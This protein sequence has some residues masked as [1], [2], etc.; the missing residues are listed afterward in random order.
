MQGRQ[1]WNHSL[2]LEGSAGILSSSGSSPASPGNVK[3]TYLHTGNTLPGKI[4]QAIIALRLKSRVKVQ[5]NLSISYRDNVSLVFFVTISAEQHGMILCFF[6]NRRAHDKGF[7]ATA[8]WSIF[9][10]AHHV[11]C[12]EVQKHT[13]RLES[14]HNH[15]KLSLQFEQDI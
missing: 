9:N 14:T 10:I 7:V 1:Y 8:L 13:F 3:S 6:D 4:E 2:P 5:S 15:H 11:C 12:C